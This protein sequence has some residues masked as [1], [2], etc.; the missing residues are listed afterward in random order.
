[1]DER[2]TL[3]AIRNVLKPRRSSGKMPR[4]L[5]AG[6]G[7]NVLAK[8]FNVVGFRVGVEIGTHKGRYARS[9]CRYN[10]KLKLYCVD[11]WLAYDNMKIDQNGQESIYNIAVG[12]LKKYN[13]EIMKKTSMEAL[14]DFNDNSLDFVYIDGNHHYEYVYEDICEWSKKVKSGG[15]IACHDYYVIFWPGVTKA[16]EQYT[17]ENDISIW[18][19][20]RDRLHTA[21]W[22]KP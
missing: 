2:T 1:M 11:P 22:V 20:T 14:G 16:V 13:A 18:F 9:I 15:I 19:A 4:P 6:Y 3:R 8:F 12:N 17:S 21:F 7:R 5:R 10:K